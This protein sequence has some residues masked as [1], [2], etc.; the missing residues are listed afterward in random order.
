[1]APH[2]QLGRRQAVPASRHTADHVH[3]QPCPPAA[4]AEPSRSREEAE[5]LIVGVRL[6]GVGKWA[7][8]EAARGAGRAAQT[9]CSLNRSVASLRDKWHS[10][11]SRPWLLPA[12]QHGQPPA[13]ARRRKQH[14][15]ELECQGVVGGG[16]VP[17]AFM[18]LCWP[19][20]A[21]PAQTRSGC[22][23]LRLAPA[24]ARGAPPAASS[25]PPTCLRPAAA[26]PQPAPPSPLGS[27]G[28]SGGGVGGGGGGGWGPGQQG[29]GQQVGCMG[30]V[31]REEGPACRQSCA[32]G[33]V[34][35]APGG[36]H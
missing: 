4:P 23:L 10:L 29:W 6:L 28:A 34:M 30:G 3:A 15:L 19:S 16:R 12:W 33:A 21:S 22:A 24:D 36:L 18:P 9:R 32:R 5:A 26:R 35:R 25:A 13:R 8:A 14:N 27:C 20:L 2:A 7:D 1:M 17:Q 11:V 31:Q